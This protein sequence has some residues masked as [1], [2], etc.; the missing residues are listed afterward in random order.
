MPGEDR[1]LKHALGQTPHI[2]DSTNITA[3]PSSTKKVHQQLP[4]TL[5]PFPKVDE[6]QLANPPEVSPEVITQK[7]ALR[8]N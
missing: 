6:I 5:L 7:R 8:T 3:P 2:Y 4:Q 1:G